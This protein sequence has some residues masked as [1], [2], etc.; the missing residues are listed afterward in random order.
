ME[1]PSSSR[2]CERQF[3]LDS[4]F[5]S[6]SDTQPTTTLGKLDLQWAS[7]R[8]DSD[9]RTLGC[10]MTPRG[11]GHNRGGTGTLSGYC[12]TFNPSRG[13]HSRKPSLGLASTN[14][15]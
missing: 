9:A 13:G 5:A 10:E 6:A 3:Q 15:G 2:K 7:V 1:C 11:A 8:P 14:R 4:L 12:L